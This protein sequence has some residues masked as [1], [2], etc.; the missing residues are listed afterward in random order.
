MLTIISVAWHN[1]C[2]QLHKKSNAAFAG[3]RLLFNA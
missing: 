2:I 3:G 1:R